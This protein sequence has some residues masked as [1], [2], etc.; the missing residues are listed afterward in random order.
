MDG[1][2]LNFFLF[3]EE[4]LSY[5]EKMAEKISYFMANLWGLY[6]RKFHL[7]TNLSQF[8][9]FFILFGL[10]F[11]NVFADSISQTIPPDFS[12]VISDTGTE[13]YRKDYQD[14]NPDFV[15]VV[16]LSEGAAIELLHGNI[17]DPGIGNGVYGGD[18]PS[19]KRQTLQEIWNDFSS[20]DTNA[21]CVTNGQFFVDTMDPTKLAFPLKKDGKYTSDGYGIGE[22]P[23]QKLILEIWDDK[24]DI[25]PLTNETL[26]SSSAP[27]IVAGLTEDANKGPQNSTGRTFIGI[28]DRNN[29]GK[30]EIVLIFNSKNAK[31]SEAAN[32]LRSFGADKII[33]FDGGGSTQLVCNGND[34]VSSSR[35][36]PQSIGVV[37]KVVPS[38]S[39][40]V[41]KQPNWP[42]LLEGENFRIEVEIENTGSDTWIP[43]SFQLENE[44]NPW[45]TNESL[46][47]PRD[48][49]PGDRIAFSWTTDR[50]SKWGI[51]TTEWY[52]T[53]DG[54]T[55][56]DPIKFSVI[57]MPKQLEDKRRELEE[58]VEE[59]SEEQ[60]E[61]IEKLVTEWIQEQIS[62]TV[63]EICNPAIVLLPLSIIVILSK[64]RKRS[65]KPEDE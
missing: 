37:S 42:I 30:H 25:V 36:V 15:Q 24:V 43:G 49:Q 35:T 51:F 44:K 31:Q 40:T 2:T 57:V 20:S 23:N 11:Q 56:T 4:Y 65:A 58:K 54:E 26:Y 13:L 63:N 53:K 7:K 19:F 16:N 64:R 5:G 32:V 10:P 29:D 48:V 60:L 9:S 45:G 52:M 55:F 50:F 18:N 41:I 59:W 1:N 39:T 14:G 3:I 46:A 38:L 47:L 22:Y 6:V 62:K 8:L 27:D 17:V 21:F 61:N 28:N 12:L 34:Y 33:M